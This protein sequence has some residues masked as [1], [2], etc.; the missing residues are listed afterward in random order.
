MDAA[1]FKARLEREGYQEIAT[2]EM[3]PSETRPPHAHD[4]D[5]AALVLEGEITLTCGDVAKTYRTGDS[6]TM[7]AG[8]PHAEAVGPNGFRYLVGRRRN[9]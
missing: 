1:E 2:A 9:A 4:F 8:L 5:V 7:K 6:F 3:R